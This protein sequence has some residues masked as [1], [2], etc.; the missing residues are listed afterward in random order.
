M[1]P[2]AE[3]I[4]LDRKALREPD[5]FQTLTGQVAAWAQANRT[6]LLGVAGAAVAV[7]VVG[8]GV[9]WY[10]S[11]QAAAAAVRFQSAHEDFQASRWAEA[12]E[13]FASLGRDYA[14]TAYGRVA[15]LYQGHALAR[16][17][18]PAA[19]T[20]AYAEFLAGA[21]ATPYL[22]QE[23]LVS[24]ARAREATGDAPGARQALEQA[25]AIEGP[26]RSD[27]RLSLARLYEAAGEPDKAKD[28][29][30]ALLKDAPSGLARTVLEAKIPADVA[31]AGGAPR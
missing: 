15:A 25:A 8:A 30:L 22:E 3:R 24:L 9:S 21:P 2:P 13:G 17:P 16:T 12:A 27:A 1:A 26:F 18:D 19:A 5:E 23:G 29:Y 14:G 6:L 7:A 31:A 11:R 10:R 4:K 20:A 28:V